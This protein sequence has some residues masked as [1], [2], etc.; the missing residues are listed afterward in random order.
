MQDAITH[1]T[2]DRTTI[3]IAQRLH[4]VA[5]ADRIFVIEEG[6]VAEDGPPRGTAAQERALCVVLPAA[7]AEPG[8][9]GAGGGKRLTSGGFFYPEKANA[10]IPR[11]RHCEPT[12][13]STI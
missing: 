7:I 6:V 13:P 10:G 11:S 2:R 8:R 12:P 1:L 4:T 3:V 9:P 5:H